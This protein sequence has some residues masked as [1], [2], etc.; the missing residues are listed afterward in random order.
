MA[1]YE[2]VF[3]AR[4]DISPNQ[5]EALA[6]DYEKVIAELKGSVKKREYWGLRTLAYQIRKN[7][8]GHYIMYNFDAPSD[9]IAEMERRMRLNDD[10]LRFMS[11]RIDEINEEPSIMM[12]SKED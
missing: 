7:K 12:A 3:I 5:V 1:L 6:D 2:T 8:K 11:I 4:Q 9:A 10:I